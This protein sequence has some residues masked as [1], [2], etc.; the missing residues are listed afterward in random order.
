MAAQPA[1]KPGRRPGPNATRETILAA[2]RELFA[3]KG[4]DG[5]SLRG[6]A[7]RAEVD[8]A[9][10][11][12]YFGNKEG[13]FIAAM[14]FPLDPEA[15]FERIADTPRERVGPVLVRTFLA[16]WGDPVRRDPML[17]MLR[18]AMTNEQVATVLREFVTSTLLARAAE[19]FDV[20]RLRVTAA[21]SQMIGVMMLRYV[22]KVEPLASA[23]EE[24]LVELLGP[25]LQRYFDN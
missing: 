15:V 8:P 2:A 25:T 12:H 6:I 21:A 24:E 16:V 4:Y 22:L 23:T 9:L 7:R 20:P 10:V 5:A 1:R 3:E 17:A 18:S 14:R 11:H 13:V 19:H